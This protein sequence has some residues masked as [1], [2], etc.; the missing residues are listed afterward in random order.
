M[1]KL[2]GKGRGEEV[3]KEERRNACGEAGG[4]KKDKA[5]TSRDKVY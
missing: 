4:I 1:R 3:E 5:V 2:E